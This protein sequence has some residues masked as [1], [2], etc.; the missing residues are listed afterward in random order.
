MAETL[1]QIAHTLPQTLWR[2]QQIRK[3]EPELAKAHGIS[4]YTLMERAGEA[5]FDC[6]KV[7]WPEARRLLIICGVGNNGGDGYVLARLARRAGYQVEL[8]QL[9]DSKRLTGD[10]AQARDL[11]LEAGGSI[12]TPA[13]VNWQAPELLI[14]ALLGT[15]LSG[16]VRPEFSD[17]IARINQAPQ[18]VLSLD[19]P[20]G[21]DS[22]SGS[23]LGC[24]VKA[25]A[26]ITF[27][28]IKRGMLTGQSADYVGKLY[29]AGLGIASGLDAHYQPAAMRDDYQSL[30]CWL[31][32]RSRYANKGAFGR[33]MLIG[34]AL[35]MPGAM[36]L[37]GGAAL[38]SGAG[39]VRVCCAS[40]NYLPMTSVHPELMVCCDDPAP[41]W[42]WASALVIGPGLGQQRWSQEMLDLALAQ[43]KPRVIDADGLNLLARQGPAA[44]E[45]ESHIL[46]PHPAEAARLLNCS[47]EE[48]EADRFAA[49]Q[50]LQERYGGVVLLKGSGTLICDGQSVYLCHEGNPGMASGGMGDLLSGIIGGLLAQGLSCTHATRLGAAIHGEAGDRAATGG[51][52]GC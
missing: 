40:E 22:D 38:R 51:S 8:A 39:L 26:T 24:A 16:E 6:L 49:V 37:A 18:P 44:L 27:V 34:S 50:K 17:L 15:G 25:Q 42:S 11:W 9:K 48:V 30:S 46:T 52:G 47:V 20:S 28:G 1:T 12:H 36:Q 43:D 41:Y 21:L 35:G 13:E 31:K 33:L 5:A 14:D 7:Q 19:I 45:G 23:I 29:F 10:A 32:P 3:A 2:A 4:M